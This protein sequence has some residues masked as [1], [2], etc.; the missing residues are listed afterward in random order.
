MISNDVVIYDF[1]NNK[2][3]DH[4]HFSEGVLANRMFHAGFKIDKH[5]YSIGGQST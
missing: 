4:L 3:K 1:Y 2:I 5:I